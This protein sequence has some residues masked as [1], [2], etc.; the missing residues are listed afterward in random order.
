MV[1]LVRV[2]H[3]NQ[4]GNINRIHIVG[5]LAGRGRQQ[6][7]DFLKCTAGL[8]IKKAAQR[9]EKIAGHRLMLDGRA[10]LQDG[11]TIPQLI[12]LLG[13]PR[14]VIFVSVVFFKG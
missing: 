9:K 11:L 10:R 6:H 3:D 14:Q 4:I 13:H 1:Q 7:F 12:T 2:A 5:L 8:A